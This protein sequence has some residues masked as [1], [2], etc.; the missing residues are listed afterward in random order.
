MNIAV[1]LRMAFYCRGYSIPVMNSQRSLLL[2]SFSRPLQMS[3]QPASTISLNLCKE[4][5]LL[6]LSVIPV[7]PYYSVTHL[8]VFRYNFCTHRWAG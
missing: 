5:L 6:P 8:S 7:I 1:M 4:Q 2:G 3:K